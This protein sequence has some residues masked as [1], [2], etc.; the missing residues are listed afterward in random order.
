MLEVGLIFIGML[1]MMLLDTK[2]PNKSETES[3]DKDFFREELSANQYDNFMV[4]EVVYQ[5]KD[6]RVKGEFDYLVRNGLSTERA[7]DELI[8]GGKIKF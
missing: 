2:S 4:D 8:R 6:N 7:V 3:Y 5:M 1:G